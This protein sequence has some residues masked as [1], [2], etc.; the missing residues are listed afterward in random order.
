[1]IIQSHKDLA[2]WQKAMDLVT[3]VYELSS[4]FPRHEVYGLTAQLRRAAVSVPANIAEGN[5][6]S[7]RRDYAR[8]LSIARGSLVEA[9]TLV[10]ISRRL[11]YT[12]G[13]TADPILL[14][15]GELSR[16]LRALHGKLTRTSAR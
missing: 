2:V 16:M 7:S 4:S 1:M 8:F 11:N 9:E 6:R 14:Q 10:L 13:N 5:A 15:I 12:G 3:Q